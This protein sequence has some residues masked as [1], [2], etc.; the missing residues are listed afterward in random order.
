MRFVLTS[1]E[2]NATLEI[3]DEFE[4][5]NSPV[6]VAAA[7]DTGAFAVDLTLLQG[8]H[9]ITAVATDAVGNHDGPSAPWRGPP[10]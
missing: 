7:D 5:F 9:T 1:F 2:P 4:G 3:F 10:P 6:G 8:T